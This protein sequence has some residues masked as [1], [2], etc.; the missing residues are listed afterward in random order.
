MVFQR[1]EELG[2]V[3]VVKGVVVVVRALVQKQTSFGSL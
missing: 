1:E 3:G 2:V